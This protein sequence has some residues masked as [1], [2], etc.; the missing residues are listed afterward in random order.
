M[1]RRTRLDEYLQWNGIIGWT[2]QILEIV[3]MKQTEV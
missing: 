2:D 1:D 3:D